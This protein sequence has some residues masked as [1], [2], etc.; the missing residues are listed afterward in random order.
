MNLSRIPAA[1]AGAAALLFILSAAK[2][3]SETT[4]P[5]YVDEN[6]T[7]KVDNDEDGKADCLDND[8]KDECAVR[9]AIIPPVMPIAAD[10]LTISGTHFNAASIRASL[11]PGNVLKTGDP[12]T[13]GTWKIQVAD[14]VVDVEYTLT[15]VAT[16]PEG[17]SGSDTASV[18]FKRTQ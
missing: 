9:I 12:Q 7:D 10:T 1:L 8:C 3:Q 14:L 2:C 11:M 16:P 5:A 13:D 18:T 6:C 15:V 4:F 17:Q